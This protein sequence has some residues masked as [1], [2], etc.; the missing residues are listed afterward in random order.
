MSL[1]HT[2]LIEKDSQLAWAITRAMEARGLPRPQHVTNGHDAIEWV[3]R[4]TFN[5]CILDYE[6]PDLNG[7]DLIVHLRQRQPNLPIF[8]LSGA[9]S[10]T[11]AVAAFRAGVTD[12]IPKD[13]QL[14]DTVVRTVQQ[15]SETQAKA[16]SLPASPPIPTGM[17]TEL[18]NPTYQN[19]LRVI[20]RQIDLNRYRMV[21]I[22]EV[23]GGFL[24]RAMPEHGR[25]ADALEFPDRDFLHWITEAYRNR[26]DGE[27]GASTSPLLPSGY[28]D[29]LRAIGSALDRHE[30]ESVT[31]A[32]YESVI[33]IG[34]NAKVDNSQ[35]TVVGNL[36]WILKKD[37]ILQILDEGYRRRR[38]AAKRGQ[39]GVLDRIFGNPSHVQAS[40]R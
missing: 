25:K 15:M 27:R 34:G 5:L 3:S 2:L 18:L 22:F 4:S 40:S 7:I 37:D 36:Q 1:V 19:R 35:Q 23:E 21:S 11:V 20:G 30:A 32:E 6:L 13:K 17:P 29:F 16:T 28:E 8:I 12:Y 10:E 24:V 33:V 14:L 26:G 38:T 31:V 39:S 9:K